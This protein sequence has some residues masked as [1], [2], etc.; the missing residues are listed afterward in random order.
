M[1]VNSSASSSGPYLGNGSNK[2]FAFG[3]LVASASEVGVLVNGVEANPATYSV[4]LTGT[5]PSAGSITFV[6]APAN[7]STVIPFPDPSFLQEL[8]FINNGAFLPEVIEEGFDRAT[9]RSIALLAMIGR[10]VR[11]APGS[12]LSELPDVDARKGL[13][14]KFDDVTGDLAIGDASGP[15]GDQGDQGI[16]GIQGL[17]GDTGDQGPAATITVGAVTTGAP[18]TNVIINNVG[19]SGAAIFDFTIPR[20]SPGASGAL[21]DGTYSGIVVSNTGLNL[22]VAA[23]HI[24]LARM[25]PLAANSFI[26]NNT[27]GA[28]TPIAMTAAQAKTLLGI[29]QADVTNLT[30]DLAAKA[31]LASPA[32]TGT[33]T[34]PT[35]ATGDNSTK[36]ATTGF[37]KAQNYIGAGGALTS[38]ATIEGE[39]IGFRGLPKSRTTTT[40]F[41]LANSDKGKYIYHTGGA[42]AGTINPNGTT[43]I[44]TDSIITIVNDGSGAITLT[45]GAGVAL[46]LNGVDANRSLAAGGMATLLKVGT[47]RWFVKGDVS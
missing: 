42:V 6:T 1:T 23:G 30:T 10:S 32:F 18:G 38:G 16:Q 14:L 33:P 40:A 15:K 11:V 9:L 13:Y 41:T 22:D 34:A 31:P 4:S 19:T 7:G 24:T 29:T 20:G 39:A 28:A 25:A 37:V 27:G 12:S 35:P 45:R 2:V 26:G 43:A 44:D 3:F 47:N 21:S 8:D 5:A 17:K 46:M 36:I